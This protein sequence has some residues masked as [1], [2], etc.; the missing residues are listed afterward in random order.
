MTAPR[1]LQSMVQRWTQIARN[2]WELYGDEGVY[3]VV[4]TTPAFL[5][6]AAFNSYFRATRGREAFLESADLRIA[7]VQDGP[8]HYWDDA[9]TLD[10]DTS[11]G[12]VFNAE[13][14]DVTETFER[15]FF[16][17]L[18]DVTLVGPDAIR[19]LGDGR[20]LPEDPLEAMGESR[21]YTS[22]V[23]LLRREGLAGL[24]QLRTLL[25]PSR[26]TEAATYP[27]PLLSL[28][29][30]PHSFYHWMV[31]FLPRLRF[32]DRY[33]A[34]TGRRPEL[35][36]PAEPSN[37]CLESLKLLGHNPSDCRQWTG[38]PERYERFIYTSNVRNPQGIPHPA[39][40][41]WVRNNLSKA[42]SKTEA[43]QPHRIYV[44]REDA[45]TRR[46]TNE[47]LLLSSLSSFG[48]QKVVLSDLD[49]AEQIRLFRETEMVVAPHGAGLVN[50]IY[51]TDLDIVELFG[52]NVQKHYYHLSNV[53]GHD[54]HCLK[55]Q[56]VNRIDLKV[57]PDVI[58]S[59]LDRVVEP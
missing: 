51:G 54:Y 7:D 26:L 44:S 23:R 10:L 5:A 13:C 39:A 30:F 50:V 40:C 29:G 11:A 56:T 46:V 35:L 20:I 52:A 53:M 3:G 21:V 55:C 42:V 9:E 16:R 45:N 1:S 18:A 49:L 43:E 38:G 14:V 17:E 25:E 47:D 31:E 36:I 37:Y 15:T 22:T 8:C 59:L 58:E 6:A 57:D 32:L 48:F 28:V 19:V 27:G 33:Q 4:A 2:G 24:P 41:R 12:E 34:E